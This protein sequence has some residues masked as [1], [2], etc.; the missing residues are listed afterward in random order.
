MSATGPDRPSLGLRSRYAF[1]NAMARGPSAIVSLIA[2]VIVIVVAIFTA[3]A[4]AAGSESGNPFTI[5]FN[6]LLQTVNGGGE[7]STAGLAAGVIFLLITVV[8]IL[9]FGAFIGALVTGMDARLEQLRQGRS[10][11]LERDHTLILG[12]SPRVFVIISELV[13]ANES[14]SNPS[15][16]VL[17][18]R[19]KAEMEDAIREQVPDMRTTRVVCRTGNPV[20]S[21]DLEMVNHRG[22]RA[23][24]V[25]GEDGDGEADAEIIKTL[26]ALKRGSGPI[27]ADRHI[28]AEIQE[29][30]TVS[31]ARLI[32]DERIELIDKP[33]TISRLIVQTSRQAGAAAV[34][35][36]IL[37]FASFEIYMRRDPD[38]S[39]LTYLDALLGYEEC[40]V[41]GL[42]HADG[43]IALNP[44]ADVV[45][46]ADDTVIALAQDDSEFERATYSR[47]ETDGD[48]IAI[49]PPRPPEPDST[50]ILGWN[51]RTPLVVAELATYAEPGSRVT[52]VAD[53]PL[54]ELRV[55]IDPAYA[56]NLEV[57]ARSA[58]TNER[59]VLDGLEVSSFDRVIVMSYVDHA[60]PQ[61]AAA[62]ALL[63]L[64]HLRDIAT[65][66]GADIAIVSEIVEPEDV[67]LVRNAGVNDI[68]VSDE[69]LSL[70]LTQVAENRHLAEVFRQLFQS[71]GS[72]V[73]V[74]DVGLY[75]AAGEPVSFATFVEAAMRRGETAIGYWR[76]D[77]ED[78]GDGM[79]GIRVSPYKSELLPARAGDRLIVFADQ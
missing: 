18:E 70:M 71:A 61:R 52:I 39:G 63:T 30:A 76:A 66:S 42:M 19:P 57:E 7:L 58:N 49:A 23:V 51:R 9:L 74:R 24:I 28:V 41:I 55:T 15:I 17:A 79:L 20:A 33:Q 47:V 4:L 22:A 8:G 46:A 36:E 2:I 59:A 44:A 37:D 5:A 56:A 38:L 43:E 32:G 29:S 45:I 69:I 50:L 75:V 68:V 35:R 31:A 65:R 48:R 60:A 26:L 54:D 40:T 6:I 34:Y 67:E 73:Y 16:V 53:L 12:W 77:A 10:L 3:V 21:A 13:L 27:S 72:E 64:L 1:D 62:R 78:R 25:L 14:R 11:V